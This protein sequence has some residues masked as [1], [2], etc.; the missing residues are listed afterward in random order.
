MPFLS[1]G[2]LVTHYDLAGPQDAPVLLL[3]NSLGTS[4]HIWDAVMPALAARFRVLRYDMRGHGLT[5]AVPL[6][7]ENGYSI[8]ALAGDA[9]ALMDALGI[10]KA[11]VCGLSIGGMV[12]QHL[13]AHAPD[14]VERLVL[15]DTAAVIGP[16]SVWNER[17]AGIRKSGLAAIA[18]GVM[19]RWFTA[20]FRAA[21]PV[22]MQGCINM[23]ARNTLDG[24]VGCA[25]AVRDADLRADGARIAT[26]TLVIVGDQDPATPPASAEALAA[27]ITG[28]RLA[29][30]ASAS[31]I[32]CV[33]Q[34]AAL[35]R[36]LVDFLS[37]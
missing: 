32:P 35:E 15:C 9:L 16:A 4:F 36:L 17:V 34:P 7:G 1:A 10:G 27:G 2:G 12:A 13:A 30:I 8:A 31:H 37:A 23:V 20:P 33:E 22:I 11:H 6:E 29:V 18:P 25:L 28:A 14:R 5:D 21:N 19:E 24:Y 3:A 26:P